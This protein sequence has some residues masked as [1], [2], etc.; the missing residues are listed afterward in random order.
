MHSE[1]QLKELFENHLIEEIHFKDNFHHVR[2][3]QTYEDGS[4]AK[5]QVQE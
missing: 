3:Y 5:E 2:F 1:E 4:K